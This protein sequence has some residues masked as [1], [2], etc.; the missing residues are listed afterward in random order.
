M[1]QGNTL[2]SKLKAAL[3]ALEGLPAS[4]QRDPKIRKAKEALTLAIQ[5]L[6]TTPGPSPKPNN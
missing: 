4:M 5:D 2:L 1:A 3:K 6:G